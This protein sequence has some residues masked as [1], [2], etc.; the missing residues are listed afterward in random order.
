MIHSHTGQDWFSMNIPIWNIYFKDITDALELGSFEGRSANY[1]ARNL[2]P[3]G[4]LICV[5]QWISKE[6]FS[7]TNMNRVEE[8]FDLN[9]KGLPIVKMKMSTQN[10]YEQLKDKKTFDFIY[11]DAGHSYSD[12][13]QDL[14]NY[15]NLLRKNGLLCVDDYGNIYFPEVKQATDTFLRALSNP[16][17]ILS[18]GDQI[19]IKKL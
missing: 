19:W 2:K 4:S 16:F 9:A 3:N 5:D 6:E 15:W 14:Q 11:V 1:I 8:C 7:N 18:V 17:E 10:A 13:L 12:C